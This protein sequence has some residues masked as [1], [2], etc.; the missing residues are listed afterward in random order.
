ML[1]ISLIAMIVIIVS[2]LAADE[3]AMPS[4]GSGGGSAAAGANPQGLEDDRNAGSGI[5]AGGSLLHF[6][7]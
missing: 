3:P 5:G 2:V 1:R 4:P 6:V 7:Q